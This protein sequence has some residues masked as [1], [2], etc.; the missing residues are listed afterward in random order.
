MP[1]ASQGQDPAA[2][3]ETGLTADLAGRHTATVSSGA[4]VDPA[5][6]DADR[7]SSNA[8]ATSSWRGS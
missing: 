7:C 8:T 1:I 5:V 6:V 2:S 4:S 3:F